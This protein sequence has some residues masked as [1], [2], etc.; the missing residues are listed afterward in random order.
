MRRAIPPAS[1]IRAVLFE[2]FC[3]DMILQV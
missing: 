1:N 3:M 2:I